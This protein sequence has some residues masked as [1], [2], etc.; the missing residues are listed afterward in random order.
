MNQNLRGKPYIAYG[1]CAA[2]VGSA[3]KLRE[4]VRRIR[5]LGDGLAMQCVAE[6]RLAGVSGVSPVLRPDLCELLVRKRERDDFEVLMMED[7]A[8]LTRAGLE[9]AKVIETEFERCGVQIVYLTETELAAGTAGQ[10]DFHNRPPGAGEAL[11][12]T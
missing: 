3:P 9:G 5:Q 11:R 2:T 7:Q 4:Q 1:R 6:L 12:G 8:R 10:D